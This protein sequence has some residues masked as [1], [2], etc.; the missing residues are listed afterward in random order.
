MEL[1]DKIADGSWILVKDGWLTDLNK[2]GFMDVV[3]REMEWWED[4]IDPTIDN[5]LGIGEKHTTDTL[6]VYLGENGDFF[7]EEF[8]IEDSSFKLFSWEK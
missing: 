4:D 5:P 1:A 3:T 6:H 8:V 7:K 2:D